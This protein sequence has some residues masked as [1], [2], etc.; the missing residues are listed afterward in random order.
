MRLSP[1]EMVF[2]QHGL[3]KL[4]GTIVFTWGL[5][6]VL[7]VGSKLITHNLSTELQRSRCVRCRADTHVATGRGV[8]RHPDCRYC[9]AGDLAGSERSQHRDQLYRSAQP[10]SDTLAWPRATDVGAVR[11]AAC[12]AGVRPVDQRRRHVRHRVRADPSL[13]RERGPGR[14]ERGRHSGKRA[15]IFAN[16]MAQTRRN[17][18]FA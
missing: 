11:S 13:R 12:A 8:R 5:M 14:E 2:W 1:D 18:P 16:R 15:F 17:R 9:A 10:R 7:V 3:L 6:F 4:N